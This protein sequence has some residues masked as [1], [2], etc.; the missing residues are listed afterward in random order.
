MGVPVRDRRKILDETGLSGIGA[1]GNG[2]DPG[3]E[4]APDPGKGLAGGL[5]LAA[6]ERQTGGVAQDDQSRPPDDAAGK[7]QAQHDAKRGF[8]RRGKNDGRN[9][10]YRRP[11]RFEQAVLLKEETMKGIAAWLLGVPIVIIIL[12]YVTG[13]F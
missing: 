6:Q 10:A 4:V 2:V 5:G 3:P 7:P 12:L 9:G 8:Q 11:V 13:I 1:L